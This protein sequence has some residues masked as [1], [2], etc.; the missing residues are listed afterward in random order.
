MVFFDY[1]SVFYLNFGSFFKYF[2]LMEKVSDHLFLLFFIV[3]AREKA[4]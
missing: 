2:P 1:L 4:L 3:S